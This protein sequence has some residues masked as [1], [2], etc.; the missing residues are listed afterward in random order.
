MTQFNYEKQFVDA[1]FCSGYSVRSL[2]FGFRAHLRQGL[3]LGL[4]PI[5]LYY[6]FHR[7][8]KP[9]CVS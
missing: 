8:F 1:P 7:V 5:S 6:L 3:G 9:F 2:F 4:K